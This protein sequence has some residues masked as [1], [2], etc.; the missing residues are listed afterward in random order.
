V[1]GEA[2]ALLHDLHMAWLQV[3]DRRPRRQVVVDDMLNWYAP[4]TAVSS[5]SPRCTSGSQASWIK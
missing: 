1:F 5:K 3:K 4:E 2:L